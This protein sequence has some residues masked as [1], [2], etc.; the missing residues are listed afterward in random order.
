MQS[1]ESKAGQQLSLFGLPQTTYMK[2]QPTLVRRELTEITT[3]P[4]ELITYD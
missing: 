4:K 2:K 1:L 3:P